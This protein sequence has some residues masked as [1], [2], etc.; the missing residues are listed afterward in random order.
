MNITPVSRMP[1]ATRVASFGYH[2]VGDDFSQSGFQRKGALPYKLG[3]NQF[4]QHL[5]RVAEQPRHP[6]LVTSIDPTRPG[7]HLLLTFDDGGKSALAIADELSQRGWRGHFFI[8]TSLIGARTF[9][10]AGEIRQLHAAGHLVG[11]H[12][13]THPDIYRDLT[14]ERMLVEWY[15]STDTL[16]QILGERCLTGA[17]PGG[18]ISGQ[19]LRS[20]GLAGL[21]YLFTSEPSL[22]PQ[23]VRGCWVLGRYCP[24]RSTSAEEIAE[25]LQ[26]RGWNNKL[27]IRR[28]KTLAR[29]SVPSFYR[30]YVHHSTREWQGQSR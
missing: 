27:I 7:D 12:S 1:S 25:L 3:V 20:A 5:D 26:L 9:L 8:V 15:Q 16:T 21:R 13:H 6:A 11:S 17:V 4:R 23:C 14:P 22:T 10:S 29:R 2:D 28:L 24:K 30:L 19:V 18:D